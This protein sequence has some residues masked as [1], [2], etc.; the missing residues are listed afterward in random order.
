MS[1]GAKEYVGPA[2]LWRVLSG[3]ALLRRALYEEV[4]RERGALRLAL[5]TALI[6]GACYGVR[7]ATETGLAPAAGLLFGLFVV[8]GHLLEDAAVVWLLGSVVAG[9]GAAFGAIVRALA[10]ANAPGAA[11]AVLAVLG[12]PRWTD[13]AVSAWLLAAFVAAIRAALSSGWWLAGGIA[14]LVRV[15]ASILDFLLSLLGG[16]GG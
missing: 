12:A 11:Y 1:D 15:M 3:G 9:Q 14:V 10:L 13:L 5:A 4:A 2:A 8:F 6:G 7:V 16:R